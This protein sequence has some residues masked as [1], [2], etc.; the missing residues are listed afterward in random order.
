MGGSTTCQ[1]LPSVKQFSGASIAI[2]AENGPTPTMGP[3]E[4]GPGPRSPNGPGAHLKC[5]QGPDPTGCLASSEILATVHIQPAKNLDQF[6]LYNQYMIT[7]ID[8][9]PA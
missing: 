5:A 8:T 6:S 4:P 2:P 7:Q 9:T 1:E 3:N